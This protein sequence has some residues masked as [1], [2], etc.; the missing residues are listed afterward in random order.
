MDSGV[1]SNI[2]Y[3]QYFRDMRLGEKRIRPTP[4]KLEDFTT[5]KVATKGIMILNV[6]LGTGLLSRTEEVENYVVGVQSL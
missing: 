5:H 3:C 6:T 1:S 2:V 4:M